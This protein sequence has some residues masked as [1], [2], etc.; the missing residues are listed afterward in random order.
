M[1]EL[2]KLLR[3]LGAELH[4]ELFK[5]LLYKIRS[6]EATAAEMNVARQ[7][8]KDNNIDATPRQNPHMIPLASELPSFEDEDALN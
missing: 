3:D 7:L 6:G 2:Q 5:K 8:L 1:S 4:L